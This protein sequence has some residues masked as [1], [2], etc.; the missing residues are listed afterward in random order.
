VAADQ[1]TVVLSWSGIGEAC[2]RIVSQV[3]ADGLPDVLVGILRGGMVPAV[4]L[5]HALGCRDVRGVSVTCTRADSVNA[6]KAS[7]PVLSNPGS[8]GQI[9]GR[10]VLIVDDVAGTGATAATAAA[11]MRALGAARVRTAVCAVNSLN[12]PADGLGPE[13]A[14]TYIGGCHRG[15]V[16]FPWEL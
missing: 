4:V 1:P 12:W 5:S 13:Q 8:A 7:R 15:W 10:D 16:I 3:T 2:R 6:A 14:L 11:L 9:A